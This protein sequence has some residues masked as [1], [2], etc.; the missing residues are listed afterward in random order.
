VIQIEPPKPLPMDQH[1]ATAWE[2]LATERQKQA[3][4]A[5]ERQLPGKWRPRTLCAPAFRA[6]PQCGNPPTGE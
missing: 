5:Y 2:I 4:D 1:N 3:I 6:L